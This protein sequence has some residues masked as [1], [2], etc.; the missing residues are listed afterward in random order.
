MVSCPQFSEKSEERISNI[1]KF[2][3]PE[4]NWLLHSVIQAD[5]FHTAWC[6]L[7]LFM[8][9]VEIKVTNDV[10]HLSFPGGTFYKQHRKTVKAKAGVKIHFSL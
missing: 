1:H 4:T 9:K 6:S 5:M 2:R 10:L 3:K 7:L 8:V